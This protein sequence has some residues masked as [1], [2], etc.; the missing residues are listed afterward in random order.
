MEHLTR[1]QEPP[2]YSFVLARYKGHPI[3]GDIFTRDDHEGHG[4]PVDDPQHWWSHTWR[5]WTSWGNL[6]DDAES[7]NRELVLIGTLSR[8]G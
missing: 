5:C 8:T 1:G 2:N 6:C 3:A 4:D 7:A